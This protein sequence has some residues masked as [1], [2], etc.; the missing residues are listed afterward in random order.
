MASR[1]GFTCSY[2]P[3]ALIHAAGLEP[4][5]IQ[6]VGASPDQ[7][8]TLVHDNMCPEV[9]RVLDRK[10]AGDL[11][12]LVGTVF[13]NSCDA[14]R[15]LA[16]AWE[17]LTG[18]EEVFLLDLPVVD[19]PRAVTYFAGQLGTLRTWL[20][21]RGDA[22][23]TDDSVVAG[24]ELYDTLHDT[25]AQLGARAAAGTLPGGRRTYQEW[26]NRASAGRAD[27]VLPALQDLLASADSVDPSDAVPLVLFG[28][29]M[30]DPAAAELVE[31]CGARIVADDLCTGS[32]LLTRVSPVDGE[33]VL[34]QLA[35]ALLSRPICARTIVPTDA[36]ALGRQVIDQVRASGAAGAVAQVAK[37]C[38][39]YL[40][41]IPAIREVFHAEGVPLLVLEGDC[42]LRSLGQ[43]RTRIEA[44]VEMLSERG[45][46]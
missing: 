1:I 35:A 17:G 40:L 14:M 28:N 36:D 18:G 5:R 44:F 8:G 3:L 46:S 33:P 2:T 32:R 26:T 37:F 16:N 6:P 39:P 21:E 19:N 45:A 11:P 12:E 13:V 23:L 42:T 15:R 34:Q 7:A 10:L 27:A 20:E 43:Q 4:Y 25:L 38:D 30:P 31:S 41:R 9:K 24:I 22:P 29:V